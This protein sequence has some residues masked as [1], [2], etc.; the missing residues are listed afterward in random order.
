METKNRYLEEKHN[1]IRL[2]DKNPSEEILTK[3]RDVEA[4]IRKIGRAHV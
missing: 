4:K 2:H 1:L 3:L